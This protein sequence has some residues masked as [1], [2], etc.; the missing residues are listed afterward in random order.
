[1]RRLIAYI[2]MAVT[3]AL[4]VGV[5]FVPVVTGMNSNI[6][7]QNGHEYVYQLTDRDDETAPIEDGAVEEVASVMQERL[8][9][10]NVSDYRIEVQGEDTIA[11][12]FVQ[13]TSISY[14]QISR[15]LSF[16]ANF[17]ICT[18]TETCAVGENLL[19]DEDAYLTFLYNVYPVVVIPIN[20]ESAEWQSVLT[21]AQK[22][23]DGITTPEEG[24]ADYTPAD[25]VLWN[26]KEEGD[27]YDAYE[28]ALNDATLNQDIV[29]KVI[30]NFSYGSDGTNLYLPDDEN[31]DRLASTT[32]TI[33]ENSMPTSSELAD[34]TRTARW[35]VNIINSSSYDYDVTC[36]FSR[37]VDVITPTI[38]SLLSAGFPG[39][40]VTLSHILIAM[41][42]I[43]VIITLALVLFYRLMSIASVVLTAAT[44]FLTLT[45]LITFSS[46]IALSAIIGLFIVTLCSVASQIIYFHRFKEENYRGRTL[47][48]ANSEASRKST[49]PI[50]DISIVM[51]ILG[52]F[53]YA[54]GGT[55]FVPFG[56]ALALGGLINV[57]FN[58]VGLK[59]MM[60]LLANSTC[61][62]GRYACFGIE[63]N[64]VPNLLNDEKQ[65]YFGSFSGSELSSKKRRLPSMAVGG[66]LALASLIA[67]ICFGAINGSIYNYGD[68]YSSN[69]VYYLTTLNESVIEQNSDVTSVL[70]LITVDGEP[71]I[72]DNV[73]IF[74]R[75]YINEED[76]SVTYH[77]FVVSLGSNYTG[78]EEA[79][80]TPSTGEAMNAPLDDLLLSVF[81]D[82]DDSVT[83]SLKTVEVLVNP[84]S[85]IPVVIASVSSL[86]VSAIYLFFRYRI[87]KNL[88]MVGLTF[89][90]GT[91][92]LGIYSLCVSPTLPIVSFALPIVTIFSI[93]IAIMYMSKEKEMFKELKVKNPNAEERLAI[94]KSATDQSATPIFIFTFIAGLSLVAF[95][96]AGPA[97]MLSIFLSALIGLILATFLMITSLGMYGYKLS[98]LLRKIKLPEIKRKHRKA[99]AKN[100]NK[101]SAEPEEAIFIGIN[102]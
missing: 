30:M 85:F 32:L 95:V 29:E 21:E 46:E 12:S 100:V 28:E 53:F 88:V 5:S 3:I 72:Y 67:M 76:V 40:S 90:A 43:L 101:S 26:N 16:S 98:N 55:Y 92:A 19:T 83:S 99:K 39:I 1:M 84:P 57:A 23:A 81:S 20:T 79:T 9:L 94:V 59:A 50:V 27:T 102:D 10:S 91:V 7:F 77:Y 31:Q 96:T 37:G 6:E 64:Q 48:K 8:D 60:Y 74:E 51:V 34:A 73:E 38:E 75:D 25:L 44:T 89:I 47:R 78:L 65:T 4:T 69:S 13:P 17:S 80:Y 97:S 52:V 54:L 68:N 87:S 14:S 61:L 71:L 42:V 63:K 56:A 35:L 45:L 36:I 41:L 49:M 86:A 11:V 22:I 18:K 2:I 15:L 66:A 33:E 82:I 70:D 58:L 62:E 24:E 93:I